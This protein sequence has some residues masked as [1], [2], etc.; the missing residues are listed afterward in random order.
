MLTRAPA[1]LALACAGRI[2]ALEG[3]LDA[4]ARWVARAAR[5]LAARAA[6]SERVFDAGG[7]AGAQSVVESARLVD[8]AELGAFRRSIDH[9]ALLL[10][11]AGSGLRRLETGKLY[12]YTSGIFL[13]VI[14]ALLVALLLV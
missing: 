4:G 8:A 3:T 11:A 1:Q 12:L 6:Q 2:D 14:A 9:F 7:R 13:W 5:T 10:G